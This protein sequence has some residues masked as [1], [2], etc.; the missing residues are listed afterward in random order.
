MQKQEFQFKADMQELLNLIIHSLYTNKEIF[1]RELVSNASDALNKLRFRR[2]T[3]SNISDPE[4]D[5]KIS[6]S[7]DKESQ[8]FAIE[9]TGIG[10]TKEDLVNQIGTVASSGTLEFFKKV[11][12]SG[13]ALDG[14]LIGQFGV[15]FYS[16]FMVADEITVET[17]HA[18]PDSKSYRWISEGKDAFTIEEIEQRPRGTKIYFKLKDDAKE[19]CE[20]YRI[21][22]ILKKY[23]NFVDFPIIVGDEEANKVNA[24]WHKPKDDVKKEELD[25]F[26]KFI[27][28]DFQEPMGHLQVAIE[29]NVNFK[30]LLFIPETA[31]PYFMRDAHEKSL[32][33]YSK[34]VFIQDDCI[35]LLPDYLKFVRGVVD[36]ED[37]PLNVSREVTQSSPVM[38]KIRNVLSS[39]I[40]GL[41]EDWAVNDKGKYDKFFK[42]FGTL[43][44]IGL[45]SDFS[46]KQRILELLRYD[47]TF[48]SAGEQ[49]SLKE[50]VDKMIESQKEIYYLA[51]DTREAIEKNPNLEYF[52][53]N[54]IPV[55]LLSDP[56]DVFTAPYIGEYDGKK[57]ISIDKANI[58][59]KKTEEE[60]AESLS[61]ETA[62][63]LVQVFR[64]TLGDKV[65]DV[66][67]SSRLVESPVTLV[68]GAQGL[69]IQME[70]MMQMMD[71]SFSVSKKILEIN[72]SHPLIKNLS[73]MN[74]AGKRKD[75]MSQC[76]IQLFEGA[77]L[78]D[79]SMRNPSDFISRMNNIMVEAT[80][81]VVQQS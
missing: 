77:L 79:G 75:V 68:V 2:L 14:Q 7:L 15:G 69:D 35:E 66:R 47:C 31:P 22:N 74:I 50:Y 13:G 44:K 5:L 42:N 61:G 28:N 12:E 67:I 48:M 36:T 57:F 64:E 30:A 81:N 6:I 58:E 20:D 33:L 59:I 55:L 56:A 60:A 3:D 52:R 10:M 53:K 16:V 40:L 65:E 34:R 26:Y 46:N 21:K 29:G 45:N 78:L 27:A 25:E 4:S 18:D 9:D 41:L 63:S 51:G 80:E 32:Q 72:T 62:N 23:S 43:F 38:T 76:I 19:F 73:M 39:R 70:K 24:L 49:C 71:K 17:R 54:S 1:L 8:T 11:K 37:L